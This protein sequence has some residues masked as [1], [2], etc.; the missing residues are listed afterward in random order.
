MSTRPAVPDPTIAWLTAED[1]P[2]VAVLV[3]REV[4]GE[5]VTPA[6]DA[7]WSRRNEYEPVARILD[8]M[9]EDGSWGR[10]SQDYRKYGGSLWQVHFLG[11][12]YA[13]G[14]DERV[15]AA[16][17]YA[18]SRQLE[19]GSWSC[20]GRPAASIPC[21]TANVGRALAR[22]GYA[23][24]ER[25]TNA[26]AYCVKLLDTF[27]CLT[28][29]AIY[30]QKDDA[31]KDWGA[32]SSTLNGYCH[33]LAPKLLLFLAE[34]P[35]TSWPD[36]AEPLRDECVRVLRDKQ[37][38]RC[39]P[40]E[41][42]EFFDVFYTAKSSERDGLRERYLGEHP[43]LHYKEK[44]GWLR[45][46]YPLSYNSDA[47]EALFALAL[48]GGPARPEYEPALD[49]VRAAADDQMRWKLRNTFNGK[50]LADVEEKGQ[51]SRWLT[52]RALRVLQHFGT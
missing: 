33:M 37:V 19:D 42:R 15:Q 12:L 5:S 39:L 38:H 52:Y 50:M 28:C 29:G 36:G 9:D 2:A 14:D 20:N 25:L 34:M 41:G 47:L 3:S 40:E 46:G 11:E 1:N 32:S 26:L 35:Q 30:S 22:L 27:G 16:A 7:L 24:D 17:A 49:V 21:L 4:L 31:P 45:F 6:L 8:L 13:S 10:P 23:D 18:F 43:L 51:P 44:A 48:H